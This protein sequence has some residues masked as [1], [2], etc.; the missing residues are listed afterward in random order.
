[1]RRDG[2]LI[3]I[4]ASDLGYGA[5]FSF[6]QE[7]FNLL[8][9]DISTFPVARAVAASSAGPV[10][11]YPVVVE[12]YHECKTELPPWLAAAKERATHNAELAQV[13]TGIE[14]F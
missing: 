6:L 10:L 1:M 9:S 3:I 2:P 8:C 7:Y 14:T 5:R 11:F 4:N 13:V 12:N